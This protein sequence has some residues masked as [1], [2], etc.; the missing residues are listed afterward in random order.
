M[1]RDLNDAKFKEELGADRLDTLVPLP[2]TDDLEGVCRRRIEWYPSCG[3]S[4]AHADTRS[5]KN[6]Q[7]KGYSRR[8]RSVET[9][10]QQQ[11]QQINK[12]KIVI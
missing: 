5:R 8:G 12:N 9:N 4:Q 6:N 10:K 11:Q 7:R 3:P 1:T 2:S